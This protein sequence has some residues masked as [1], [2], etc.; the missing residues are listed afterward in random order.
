[1]KVRILLANYGGMDVTTLLKSSVEDGSFL[2]PFSGLIIPADNRWGDPVCGVRKTL[3]VMY[4]WGEDPEPRVAIVR[5]GFFLKI[6]AETQKEHANFAKQ[7]QKFSINVPGAA[8]ASPVELSLYL[9]QG[10]ESKLFEFRTLLEDKAK[11]FRET[12]ATPIDLLNWVEQ[13]VP[14]IWEIKPQPFPVDLDFTSRLCFVYAPA[15]QKVNLVIYQDTRLDMALLSILMGREY[16]P[17]IDPRTGQDQAVLDRPITL[18]KA[19][20]DMACFAT[21]GAGVSHDV[22]INFDEADALVPR[23]RMPSEVFGFQP[24]KVAMRPLSPYWRA[25]QLQV[26]RDSGLTRWPISGDD[27]NCLYRAVLV[28]LWQLKKHN[29]AVKTPF[30]GGF[31]LVDRTE[32][33]TDAIHDIYGAILREMTAL[34]IEGS[35]ELSKFFAEGEVTKIR[36][37]GFWGGHGEV[38]A[39]QNILQSFGMHLMVLN[40]SDSSYEISVSPLSLLERL[41]DQAVVLIYNGLN[42]Y[43]LLDNYSPITEMQ[44]LEIMFASTQS[45]ASA[46]TNDCQIARSASPGLPFAVAA[47]SPVFEGDEREDE[48]SNGGAGQLSLEESVLN[49]LLC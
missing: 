46:S 15:Q 41:R 35:A 27:H 34:K 4:L 29:P 37:S 23:G 20:S 5:E 33:L 1:M 8:P 13:W 6:N 31:L 26:L 17:F 25:S 48:E 47:L 10:V 38:V 9:F 44:S 28:G 40:I 14:K 2:D 21:G 43:D 45:S 49:A 7:C 24:I 30:D 22:E 39:L 42:H 32:P 12:R 11:E 18:F 19:E 36:E 3:A 16:P